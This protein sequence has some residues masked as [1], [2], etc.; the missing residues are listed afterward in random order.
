MLN[1]FIYRGFGYDLQ[2]WLP[3]IS[4]PGMDN[5][6]AAANASRQYNIVIKKFPLMSLLWLGLGLSVVAGAYYAAFSRKKTGQKKSG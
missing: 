6:S 1:P 2:V 5:N 3:A 4:Y